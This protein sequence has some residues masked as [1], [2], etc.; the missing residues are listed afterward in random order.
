VRPEH[1]CQA[2]AASPRPSGACCR[3]AGHIAL[4]TP[5]VAVVEIHR[6][7]A[8]LQIPASAE[9]PEEQ[10]DSPAWEVGQ[11]PQTAE[12][13]QRSAGAVEG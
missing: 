9:G 6:V 1:T 10:L 11:E 12:W 7:E 13:L 5:G 2:A 8:W 4:G 3:P